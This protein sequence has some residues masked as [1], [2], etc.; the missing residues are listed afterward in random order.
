MSPERKMLPEV[1]AMP[2]NTLDRFE[3]SSP[4]TVV[5][6]MPFHSVTPLIW[7]LICVTDKCY[8]AALIGA[9][10]DRVNGAPSSDPLQPV[11]QTR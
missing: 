6:R 3:T 4:I 10:S 11:K 8:R 5:Q 9:D 1:E 7:P 2:E